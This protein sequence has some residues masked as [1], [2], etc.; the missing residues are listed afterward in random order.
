MNILHL[1]HTD[2]EYD[3]RIIKQV[4]VLSSIR[5]YNVAGYGLES[6][7]NRLQKYVPSG[8]YKIKNFRQLGIL[9]HF[10]RPLKHALTLFAITLKFVVNGVFYRPNVIHCHDTM[11]LPAGVILKIICGSKLIY[12][13]HELESHK[14]GQTLVLSKMTFLIEWSLWRIIDFFISVSPSIVEWYEEKLGVKPNEIILN[15]PLYNEMEK[16]KSS[17]KSYFRMKYG[18]EERDIIFLYLGI[19]GKGR[20][21]EMYLDIFDSQSVRSHI[22]FMGYGDLVDDVIN[23][24]KSCKKI[25]YHPRV[26]HEKVVEISQSADIGLAVVEDISLSDY[27]CLPNKLF[28]YAFSGIPVLVSDFPDMKQIVEKYKLGVTTKIDLNSVR[29]AI[30]RIQDEGLAPSDCDLT[31]ISWQKQSLKLLDVYNRL[32]INY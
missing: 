2:I 7:K 9:E 30:I 10:P 14:N 24:S 32:D 16:K 29:D 23:M 31:P 4:L 22:V 26:E 6:N 11:V 21:V 19:I 3:N 18:I 5:S 17:N 15:S 25:H 27:Y 13:A 28:E 8:S 12:D 1:T 20:G